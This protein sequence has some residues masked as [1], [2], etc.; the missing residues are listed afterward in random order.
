MHFN[1]ITIRL[2]S[3]FYTKCHVL[4]RGTFQKETLILMVLMVQYLLEEMQY[5]IESKVKVH[6]IY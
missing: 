1:L 5:D 6:L 2:W 3:D 4:R